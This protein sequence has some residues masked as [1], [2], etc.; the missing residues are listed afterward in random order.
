MSKSNKAELKS[1][2][3]SVQSELDKKTSVRISE[4][5]FTSNFLPVVLA[6]HNNQQPVL[7]GWVE[8]TGSIY[9]GFEVVDDTTGEVLYTTPG[10]YPNSSFSINGGMHKMMM[11]AGH[12]QKLHLDPSSA[13]AEHLNSEKAQL[14]LDSGA[15]HSIAWYRIFSKYGIKMVN[16]ENKQIVDTGAQNKPKDDGLEW[17]DSEFA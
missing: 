14:Q 17:G 12:A 4:T 7:A 11:D 13:Y 10:I 16:T 6:F 15:E 9:E 2:L 8:R 1:L 5:D 3:D